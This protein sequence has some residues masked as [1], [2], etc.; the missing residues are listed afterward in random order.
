M[1]HGTIAGF[2]FLNSAIGKGFFNASL[3]FCLITYTSHAEILY[4]NVR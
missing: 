2:P 3:G 4:D 1:D